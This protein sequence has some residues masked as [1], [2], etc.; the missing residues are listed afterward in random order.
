M[1]RVVD[2]QQVSQAEGAAKKQF[3]QMHAHQQKITYAG[4]L[5]YAAGHGADICKCHN[6]STRVLADWCIRT[7]DLPQERSGEAGLENFLCSCNSAS[8]LII[9]NTSVIIFSIQVL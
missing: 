4:V 7:A 1:A 3:M 9:I 5:L 6:S 2:I 8:S